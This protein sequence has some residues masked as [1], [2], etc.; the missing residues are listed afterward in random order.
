MI[1][2]SEAPSRESAPLSELHRT[3]TPITNMNS[4][5]TSP[6]VQQYSKREAALSSPAIER[7]SDKGKEKFLNLNREFVQSKIDLKIRTFVDT[8]ID[9]FISDEISDSE[10]IEIA[11]A[12]SG[13]RLRGED[14]THVA[15]E[16]RR[17]THEVIERH[18]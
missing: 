13:M 17:L 18:F 7:V 11:R 5:K 9:N 6:E 4:E 10:L 16:L 14:E 1:R 8:L 12:I 15:E 2:T 3:L